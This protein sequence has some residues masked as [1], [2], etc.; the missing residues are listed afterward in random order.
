MIL[1]ENL[2]YK[3]QDLLQYAFNMGHCQPSSEMLLAKYI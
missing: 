2:Q 3:E 1:L